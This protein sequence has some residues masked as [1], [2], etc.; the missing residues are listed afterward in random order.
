M[1]IK[2]QIYS[3][4]QIFFS[5]NWRKM[6]HWN[7]ARYFWLL[8]YPQNPRGSCDWWFQQKNWGIRRAK[9]NTFKILNVKMF[10]I[11][12]QTF[13]RFTFL[14]LIDWCKNNC[15]KIEIAVCGWDMLIEA[16]R[17][18]NRVAECDELAKIS[19]ALVA[20]GRI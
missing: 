8:E 17:F 7:S 19:G 12:K 6:K 1:Y 13:Q 15:L 5:E 18:C 3:R 20:T 11:K 9:K 14:S 4:S 10:S 2:A 16:P